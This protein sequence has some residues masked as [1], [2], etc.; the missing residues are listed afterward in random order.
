MGNGRKN[1]CNR[2]GSEWLQLSGV[3]VDGQ[4]SPTRDQKVCP[5]CGSTDVT[6]DPDC[7]ILWD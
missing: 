3:G 2:C 6:R 7:E 5:H 1:K 4:P